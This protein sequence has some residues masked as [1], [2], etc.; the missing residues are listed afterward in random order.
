[1]GMNIK[2]DEAHALA[3]KIASHTGESLTS[4]VVVALKERLERIERERH[5]QEKIRRIDEILAKLPP[6]PPGVTSDHSD[7]YDD[8]GLPT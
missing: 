8:D 1:M 5:A 7:L 2:S 6:V 4:A 3:K